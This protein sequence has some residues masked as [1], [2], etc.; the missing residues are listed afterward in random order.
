MTPE[1]SKSEQSK[2]KEGKAGADNSAWKAIE[3]AHNGF[4]EEL[5]AAWDAVQSSLMD[6][7]KSYCRG[8]EKAWQTQSWK[9]LQTAQ[10]EITRSVRSISSDA[11]VTR[12][13]NAAYVK[14]REA[15]KAV[16]ATGGEGL[17]PSAMMLVAQSMFVVSMLAA[18][19]M[20]AT[21]IQP[22]A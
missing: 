10:D 4:F 5:N 3:A 18:Q 22:S 2:S 12:R 20:A 19:Q 6:L 7:Q 17:P 16:L 13:V 21:N 15:M 8:L 9:E 11:T 1:Q 14:Y